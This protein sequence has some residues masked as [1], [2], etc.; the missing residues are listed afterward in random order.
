MLGAA[1]ARPKRD[2][3]GVFGLGERDARLGDPLEPGFGRMAAEHGGG[4][5]RG[6]VAAPC[7]ERGFGRADAQYE[8]RRQQRCKLRQGDRGQ[9]PA[10]GRERRRTEPGRLGTERGCRIGQIAD[11]RG[12]H[13]RRNRDRQGA[14]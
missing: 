3:P 12:R 8:G 6:E 5:D 1:V 9:R 4:L 10:L 14:R 7:K 2:Q 11:H 13:L